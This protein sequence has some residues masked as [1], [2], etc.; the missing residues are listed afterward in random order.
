MSTTL[1][2]KYLTLRQRLQAALAESDRG[3]ELLSFVIIAGAVVAIAALVVAGYRAAVT[4][5]LAGL[6]G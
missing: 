1:V 6:G 2:R 4:G 5:K 3:N